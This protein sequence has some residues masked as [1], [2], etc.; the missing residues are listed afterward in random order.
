MGIKPPQLTEV[1]KRQ[2]VKE[3]LETFRANMEAINRREYIKEN[4][5]TFAE[6]SHQYSVRVLYN[7]INPYYN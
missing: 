5:T 6:P 7:K 2:L 1:Q 4:G 3:R